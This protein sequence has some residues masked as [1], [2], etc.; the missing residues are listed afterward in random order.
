[1]KIGDSVKK[2]NNSGYIMAVIL[3][4][5]LILFFIVFSTLILTMNNTFKLD[6]IL[7]KNAIEAVQTTKAEGSV[8]L[9]ETSGT[10]YV[11]NTITFI[12]SNA[13]GEISCETNNSNIATCS[14]SNN[15]VTVYGIA[16]GSATITVN[17]AQSTN[18]SATS[19]IYLVTVIQAKYDDGTDVY[20]NPVTGKIC[21]EY[22]LD[23][24]TTGVKE[25][26]LKWYI[27]N[28]NKSND[29]LTLL[30]DHNTTAIVAWDS[31]VADGVAMNEV[32][33]SLKEDTSNWLA[34]LNPRLITIDEVAHIVGA[35]R[36]DTIKFLSTKAYGKDDINT[37]IAW[38][39]LD[40]SGTSYSTTDGWELK[41]ANG[42]GT[43][44]YPWL[45]DY[46]KVCTSHGCNIDDAATYGYW[47]SNIL[48]DKEQAW[49]VRREGY[50]SYSS[51]TT[52]NSYG[53]RPV[54]TIDKQLVID[55]EKSSE[56]GLLSITAN[57][58]SGIYDG[59]AHGIT[60]MSSG[61]TIKYGTSSGTYDLNESPKYTNAG[62]YTVYYE[63]TKEGYNK[64]T[65]SKQVIISKANGSATLS[66]TSGIVYTD[67][68]I[69]FTVS[70][71]T[72]EISC[73]TNNSNIAT[74]SLSGSTITI[75]GVSEGSATIT[76]NVA[77]STNYND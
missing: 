22:I 15:T 77:Q 29:K 12:V 67:N 14:I 30:L 9:S 56:E 43:S 52:N 75:K 71:A 49:M 74:C 62:T 26:C 19:K 34:I 18:Y 40:G 68:T 53:V 32:A 38:F 5:V 65:G 45:Y 61:A 27:F 46:T 73:K 58:Y 35:D 39:Y 50:A 3:F 60:V 69:T 33:T 11:G 66:A 55:E 16:E 7:K 48:T 8:T 51:V 23:N 64:V 21:D 36:E 17:V 20:F 31:N 41:V 70:N 59:K 24:S 47:T 42:K 2:L 13:T 25:G 63:V 10:V 1:M 57:G 54:I 4:A 6:N 44:K 76:V 37:K 72:G 28:D